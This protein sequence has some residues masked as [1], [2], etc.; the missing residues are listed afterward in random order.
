ML[1]EVGKGVIQVEGKSG[2]VPI[3]SWIWAEIAE[4]GHPQASAAVV[5]PGPGRESRGR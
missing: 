3:G 5:I 4:T 2:V 1:A